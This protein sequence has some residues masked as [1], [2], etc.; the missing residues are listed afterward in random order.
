MEPL[1]QLHKKIET[2]LKRYLALETENSRMRDIIG[3]QL[4]SIDSMNEKMLSMEDEKM[5]A[6]IGSI[7]LSDE[8]KT[9]LKMQID[10]AISE[11]DKMLTTL[12][13]QAQ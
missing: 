7:E 11:I 9:S 12:N 2:L 5:N 13:E 8:E 3:K 6:T 10:T 4:Q 1:Q